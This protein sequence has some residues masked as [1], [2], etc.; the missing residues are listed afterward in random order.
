MTSCRSCLLLFSSLSYLPFPPPPKQ[1]QNT[2]T[3]NYQ[4]LTEKQNSNKSNMCKDGWRSV[5]VLLK[6]LEN[7]RKDFY[8]QNQATSPTFAKKAGGPW[9]FWTAFETHMPTNIKIISEKYNKKRTQ[10]QIQ[11]VQ[12]WL[13][14]CG[15]SGRLLPRR[16]ACPS[17][18]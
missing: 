2:L 3:T 12:R 8:K 15:C 5:L 17:P 16:S 7:T 9:L 14:V 11:S 6:N 10:Q 18:V 1:S 4:L 13:A